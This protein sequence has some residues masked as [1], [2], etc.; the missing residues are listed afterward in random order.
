MCNALI[1]LC[2]GKTLH[3]KALVSA[4][5]QINNLQQCRRNF[6]QAHLGIK[7]LSLL[8]VKRVISQ[9]LEKQRT[10]EVRS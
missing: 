2:L 3:W 9:L 8:G 1:H 7:P 5:R 4:F 6:S 10:D